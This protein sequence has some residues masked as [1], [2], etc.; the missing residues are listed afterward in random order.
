[1]GASTSKVYAMD[2]RKTESYLKVVSTKRY[3]ITINHSYFPVLPQILI[4][5]WSG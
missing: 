3:Y 4:Q 5:L 1:M 2:E